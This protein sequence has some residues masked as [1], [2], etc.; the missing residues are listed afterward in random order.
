MNWFMVVLRL[1][2]IGAGVFWAGGAIVVARFL[3]P[4]V[5]D[6]GPEGGKVVQAL[7]KRGLMTALPVAAVVS[8]L[9]GLILY[10]RVSGTYAAEFSRTPTG[11]ALG[12]GAAAAIIAFVIGISV[13]RPST[14]KAGAL[15]QAVSQLPDAA[16]RDARQ[17][18]IQRLRARAASAANWVAWL[19][20]ISVAAM[21]VARYL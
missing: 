9:A 7:Q 20:V 8:M 15:A 3:I 5:Q 19:L 4:A 6:A 10:W 17:A 16:A 14:M 11:I 13:M 1:I 2:H 21:A 18:E 12:V